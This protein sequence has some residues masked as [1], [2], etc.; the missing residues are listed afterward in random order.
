MAP[1]RSETPGRGEIQLPSSTDLPLSLWSSDWTTRSLHYR[2]RHLKQLLLTDLI[3]VAIQNK[4]VH[5]TFIFTGHWL[6]G[7][8]FYKALGNQY[9]LLGTCLSWWHNYASVICCV[10]GHA[11]HKDPVSTRPYFWKSPLLLFSSLA[12]II[13]KHKLFCLTRSKKIR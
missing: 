10:N 13:R 2:E 4:L 11:S 12:V 1:V 5:K 9:P 6:T 3:P 8:G 7:P